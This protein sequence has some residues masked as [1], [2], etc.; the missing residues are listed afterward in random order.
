MNAREQARFDMV[1]SVGTEIDPGKFI[2]FLQTW[3][4]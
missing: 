2:R 4:S 3:N 1:K